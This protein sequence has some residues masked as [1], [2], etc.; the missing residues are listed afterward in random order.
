LGLQAKLLRVLNDRTFE[1]L[2]SNTPLTVDVRMICAT[3]R[4]LEQMVADGEFREDLYYRLNVIQLHLPPLRER[5]G[6]IVVLAHH[7]LQQISKELGKKVTRYSPLAI[8]ALDEYGWP[9][10]VRELENVIRRAVVLAEGPI[11]EVW[12][13]PTKLRDNVEAAPV[14][15]SYEEELRDFKRR[16]LVRTLQKSNGNKAEAARVLG[17]ARGYLHRLIHDLKIQT[18]ETATTDEPA[19]PDIVM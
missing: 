6:G 4:N 16:L 15:R 7:L 17:V 9:G 13:L 5:S 3:H 8:E 2:G 18:E 11:I 19:G 12:H 14:T 1:R 10:N